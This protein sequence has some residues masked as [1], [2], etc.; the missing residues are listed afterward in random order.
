MEGLGATRRRVLA[1]GLTANQRAAFA[2]Y[3][4]LA[5]RPPPELRAEARASSAR[6]N[7]STGSTPKRG[8]SSATIPALTPM[9]RGASPPVRFPVERD[10]DAIDGRPRIEA[11]A[12][13]DRE[14][15]PA[16][17]PDVVRAARGRLDRPGDRAKRAIADDPSRLG[18]DPPEPVDVDEHERHRFLEPRVAM[19]HL[20]EPGEERAPVEGPGQVIERRRLAQLLFGRCDLGLGGRCRHLKLLLAGLELRHLTGAAKTL[21]RKQ[22]CRERRPRGG[23]EGCLTLFRRRSSNATPSPRASIA[24]RTPPTKTIAK[25][26]AR[27]WAG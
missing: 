11:L 24:R 1:N 27:M 15:V 26:V 13:H 21:E 3:S 16:D 22:G 18:V 20:V 12:E 4:R 14:L 9:G 2:R 5:H 6:R 7:S 8:S 17:A 23:G 10:E 19:H 25:I